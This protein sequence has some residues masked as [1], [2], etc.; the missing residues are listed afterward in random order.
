MDPNPRVYP[1]TP[2]PPFKSVVAQRS[3][4]APG[5][6]FGRRSFCCGSAKTEH[7]QTNHGGRRT[8]CP[9]D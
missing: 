1:A 8:T 7:P 9:S 2:T 6:G 5:V 3:V 4:A